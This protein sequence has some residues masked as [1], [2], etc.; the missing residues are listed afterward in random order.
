MNTVIY[1]PYIHPEPDWLKLAAICWDKVYVLGTSD[2]VDDPVISELDAALGGILDY[3]IYVENIADGELIER[4]K[5]WV[6]AREDK[7][8]AQGLKSQKDQPLFGIYPSKNF[9]C[10]SGE[11]IFDLLAR[12]GL[13]KYKMPRLKP[14]EIPSEAGPSK[15]MIYMPQDIALHYLSLCASK[16]AL[17]GNRDVVAA[18]EKYTDIVFYDHRVMRG[19]V[20]ALILNAYLPDNF[21]SMALEQVKSFRDEFKV[22]RLKY[23][24]AVQSICREFGDAASEGE[25]INI[26][27]RVVEIANERIEEVRDTYRRAKLG[28]AIKSFSIS[29]TPPAIATGIASVLGVGLFAPAAVGAALSLFAASTL[30]EW[31]KAKTDRNKSPWSYV[32]DASMI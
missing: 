10:S 31:D 2:A 24:Q 32:L 19:D 8:R 5:R 3:S 9:A 12:R 15:E 14:G 30:L 11:R 7:L 26:K 29:L 21:Y 17:S 23:D 18:D 22:Q 25:L 27:D 16:A 28:V 13:A 6:D 20:A 1:Y 4:F